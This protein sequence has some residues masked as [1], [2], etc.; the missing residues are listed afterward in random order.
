MGQILY[1]SKTVKIGVRLAGEHINQAAKAFSFLTPAAEV[2]NA[3]PKHT[4]LR[5]R[6][7]A[8]T[9]HAGNAASMIIKGP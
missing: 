4:F 9:Y 2:P 7:K 6:V 3:I 8:P 1:T 5:S